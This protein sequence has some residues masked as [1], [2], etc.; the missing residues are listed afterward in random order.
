MM[1]RLLPISAVFA[2]VATLACAQEGA[3]PTSAPP[4]IE[5][6][7]V[8]PAFETSG[9]P[10][11]DAWRARFAATAVNR[12]GADPAIVVAALTGLTPDPTVK[13][14]NEAQPELVRPIWDYLRNAVSDA[15][16]AQGRSELAARRE[17]LA[18]LVAAHGVPPEYAI[19]IWAME[20]NFGAVRGSM[21]VV[22]SLAT[23][24][25]TGRRTA[26]G[27]RE[28]LAVFEIL[29][30][31]EATRATLVGSWAGAMGHT[32][33]MPTS[34]L[35]RAIDGDGDGVRNIWTDA[36]D[37]L[38]STMNYLRDAGWPAG[39]IWGFQTRLPDGFDWALSDG[40]FRP[41]SAWRAAGFAP[42]AGDLPPLDDAMELRL[43]VP[44]G[45]QGPVFLVGRGYMAIRDYN[46]SD[47]YALAVALI[48]DR[49]AGRGQMPTG[50]PTGNPPV[51]RAEGREMQERLNMLGFP[52][53]TPDGI[54]GSNTRRQLQAFQRSVGLIP[55]G[56]PSR[57]AL[58]AL[59]GAT[60]PAASAPASTD[61]VPGPA[62]ATTATPPATPAAT[63]AASPTGL[64][65]R[66]G[67]DPA[68]PVRLFGPP[69]PPPPPRQ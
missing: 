21:D 61:P 56:Y 22:R 2:A 40:A 18:P 64:R 67:E 41:L 9:S 24:A 12:H 51:Q 48:G 26:L 14:L 58:E 62:D 52:V 35:A 6:A 47:S 66:P 23:L 32:Q 55:D 8:A 3:T 53:G 60:N 65:G 46:A 43:L 7:W 59:R 39:Q 4:R 28:L 33:F 31:Q 13:R 50:W 29:R 20:S 11:F 68:N 45:A 44:A 15:R 38:A 42:V 37:G 34:F 30:R 36:D 49:I 1:A 19:A 57:E 16:L 25:Y 69:A 5:P 54:A 10:E 63:P 27:E 17:R